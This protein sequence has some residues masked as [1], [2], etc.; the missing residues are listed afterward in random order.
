LARTVT[1]PHSVRAAQGVPY[2]RGGAV[3]PLFERHDGPLSPH[4]LATGGAFVFYF[5]PPE[6]PRVTYETKARPSR[7]PP[8]LRKQESVSRYRE[9]PNF[10]RPLSQRPAR[11]AERDRRHLRRTTPA[12]EAKATKPCSAP[13][14]VKSQ[15]AG[16]PMVAVHPRPCPRASPRP[17]APGRLRQSFS[18]N[19]P[20]HPDPCQGFGYGGTY[21]LFSSVYSL[22]S[23]G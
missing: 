11:S 12:E 19:R 6:E 17:G 9:R 18:R 1:P 21:A 20:G 2:P 5:G 16:P 22:S 8:S 23:S 14:R 10:A 3:T 4:Y 13:V 7:R 15:T